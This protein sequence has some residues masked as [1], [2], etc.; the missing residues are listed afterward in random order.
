MSLMD[1]QKNRRAVRS[2]PNPVDKATIVSLL[3]REVTETKPT[4]QPGTFTI[5]AGTKEKPGILIIGSSSWWREIDEGQP[6]L[7]IPVSSV[8]VA[9]SIVK[10]YCNGLLGCDMSEAMPGLFYVAGAH[11]LESIKKNYAGMIEKYYRLQRKWFGNLVQIADVMWARSNGNPL[12]INDDARLA[13][14][15]LG[16]KDKPWLKDFHAAQLVQCIACGSFKNPDFPICPTC[17]AIAD[18]ELAKKLGIQFAAK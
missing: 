8:Q 6:L 14:E 7:E 15:E 1:L 11:N 17:H 10:D 9:D 13:C 18:V 16:F 3:P 12:A 4:I 5:P 2:E